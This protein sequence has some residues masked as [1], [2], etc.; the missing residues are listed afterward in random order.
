MHLG[1]HPYAVRYGFFN[2]IDIF[3]SDV[4]FFDKID[5]CTFFNFR[6]IRRYWNV[7]IRTSYISIHLIVNEITD[8][9]LHMVD[10]RDNTVC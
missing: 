4:G 10:I 6:D 5:K 9:Y 1:I 2:D 7:I 3:G 8:Q